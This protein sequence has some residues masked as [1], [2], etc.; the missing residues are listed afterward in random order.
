MMNEGA[1]WLLL[2]FLFSIVVLLIVVLLRLPRREKGNELREELRAL[3]EEASRAA[4][5]SREELSKILKDANETLVSTLTNMAAVQR[6]QLDGMTDQIQKFSQSH[7]D[8]FSHLR[9]EVHRRIQ[10]LQVSHDQKSDHMRRTLDEKMAAHQ[11]QLSQG[12]KAANETLGTTLTS[13]GNFQTTQL[14]T[15]TTQCTEIRISNESALERTRQEL[16]DGLTAASEKLTLNLNDI[17]QVQR[18][19]L[20]DMKNQFTD[21]SKFNENSLDR[22]RNTLDLRV[23]EL[24]DSNERKLEDMRKTVDE[25]LHETLE[26]RLQASFATVSERLEAVHRGLGEMQNLATGVGDLQR[27][28]TNVKVRGTWAEV[29]LGNL[30]DQILAPG[31]YERN[32]RV[33]ADSSEVVEYAVRLPGTGGD[34]STCLWLPIDSKFPQEDYRRVQDAADRADPE[35]TKKAV[36]DLVRTIRAE[37]QKICERYINPPTTTDFAIMFLA[38]EGLYGEVLRQ[39]SLVEELQRRFRVVI[40]GPTTLIAI[41][42]SLRMGFQTLAIEQRASEVAKVLGAVKTEFGKFNLLLDKVKRQLNT[43]TRTIE[44]SGFRRTRAIERALRSVEQLPEMDSAAVLQI[45][46]NDVTVE[47]DELEEREVSISP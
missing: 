28:L 6:T 1:F 9:D 19:Q 22:I 34:P 29:Q 13:I 11:E 5:D 17:W 39:A 10:D 21:F 30:L 23:K 42:N 3:R 33:K 38:T 44:E 14:E 45:S 31:Q 43:A 24:Q 37:A 20:D 40:A 12:L 32:V 15:V 26:N 8:S 46:D 18:I 2:I 35:E 25:K 7:Y 27:V 36:E 4:K 16:A 41:L 47:L